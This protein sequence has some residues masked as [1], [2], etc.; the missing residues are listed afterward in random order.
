MRASDGLKIAFTTNRG[1]TG[2][3]EIYVMNA[4]GSSPV[5]L[6]NSPANESDPDWQ[7]LPGT[8]PAAPGPDRLCKIPNLLGQ[9]LASA[10][11]KVR[12]AGCVSGRS[13]T[14]DRSARAAASFARRRARASASVLVSA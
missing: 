4:D 7:P 14:P 13:G 6:T 1:P 2:D 11:T 5:D 8:P 10:R 9:K 12:K 3:N